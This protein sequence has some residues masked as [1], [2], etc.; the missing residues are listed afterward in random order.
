MSCQNE[1]YLLIAVQLSLSHLC[2]LSDA[3]TTVKS[4]AF[5][6]LMATERFCL[7]EQGHAMYYGRADAVDEWFRRLGAELPYRMNVADYILDLASGDA[8]VTGRYVQY[9]FWNTSA[10][11]RRVV[12]KRACY[13]SVCFNNQ[14]PDIC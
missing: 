10:P 2:G 12:P 6:R 13:R 8:I 4:M 1:F 9:Q 7:C 3:T 11:I 14:G 5:C